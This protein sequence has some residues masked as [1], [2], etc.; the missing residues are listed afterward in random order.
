MVSTSKHIAI[1]VAVLANAVMGLA[2]N[3]VPNGSFE[4]YTVCPPSFGYA[5]YA[6]GWQNLHTNSADYFNRCNTGLVA[7]VPY[8]SF[9]Y[10]E[11]A[12]GDAYMG[13]VTTFPGL[14]SYRE[15]V[16][17]EL[18]EPLVPGVPVCIS[19][20]VAV[21][22]FGSWNGNSAVYT[23]KGIGVQFFTEFPL[24]WSS[25][26]FPNNSPAYLDIVPTDTSSWYDVTA[27]YVPDSAY[28]HIAIGNF[29]NDNMSDIAV[30]DA[31][32][33]IFFTSYSLL[34][35]V[36]LLV[37]NGI[38]NINNIDETNAIYN[39]S[40]CLNVGE[41]LDT[42]IVFVH[43]LENQFIWQ[44]F[45]M[46]GRLIATGKQSA[47]VSEFSIS[48]LGLAKGSYVLRAYDDE[49]MFRPLRFFSGSP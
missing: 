15:I 24:N 9:G 45:D 23:A 40:R 32:Y 46:N 18:L 36:K 22:G 1:L 49:G 5:Q 8:N 21:G 20:K 34:D 33:G 14:P 12:D 17:T 7:G 31:S 44:L 2:Q 35:D 41:V 28:T 6:T 16:G 42:E 30:I 11:P 43:K 37:Q 47:G 26:L 4:E 13:L 27:L 29:F 10:Q 3:L 19:F 48:T 38:C 25:F 39:V